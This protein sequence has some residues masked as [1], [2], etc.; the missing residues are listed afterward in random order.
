MFNRVIEK[1]SGVH[2]LCGNGTSNENEQMT[3]A[4]HP[5]WVSPAWCG[6]AEEPDRKRPYYLVLFTLSSEKVKLTC[7]G[8]QAAHGRAGRLGG[9]TWGCSLCGRL[10]C[11]SLWFCSFSVGMSDFSDLRKSLQS[12][13][14]FKKL[15]MLKNKCLE[16][17][18]NKIF[19]E[20]I[21]GDQIMGDFSFVLC[22]ENF[23]SFFHLYLL[24]LYLLIQVY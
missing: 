20:V 18:S 23:H 14:I 21:T 13:L 3:A 1:S 10:L 16:G 15:F 24:H 12:I 11:W 17:W 5:G 4:Y 9:G 6:P 8:S 22:T 19:D 2:L 7:G